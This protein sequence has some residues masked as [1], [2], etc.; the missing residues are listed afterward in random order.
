[1]SPTSTSISTS[2]LLLLLLAIDT[3]SLLILD[4]LAQIKDKL[5]SKV[6]GGQDNCGC[7]CRE[8]NVLKCDLEWVEH[9]Y[10]E[11]Y[12]TKCEQRQAYKPRMVRPVSSHNKQLGKVSLNS[13][14]S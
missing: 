14:D 6:L 4:K 12:H 8:Y 9:C 2:I 10:Q 1:M 11:H 3:D 13:P 5:V 7:P